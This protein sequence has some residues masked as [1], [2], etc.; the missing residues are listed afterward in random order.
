MTKKLN[1]ITPES[2]RLS[3]GFSAE[4]INHEYEINDLE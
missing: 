3:L 4:I 1:Q 2:T